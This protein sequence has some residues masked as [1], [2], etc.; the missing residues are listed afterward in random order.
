MLS[1]PLY[2]P[3]F[4]LCLKTAFSA[5][6]HASSFSTTNLC[7][8]EEA[9]ALL[10]F[11]TS[12]SINYTAPNHGL[13]HVIALD[14]SCS[15]LSGTFPSN[16]T[17]FLLK[18]LQSLSLS[19]ID[20]RLSKISP[21]ISQFTR[22]KHLDISSSQ[23]SG[24]VPAEIAH[25][26]KLVSLNLSTN[27]GSLNLETATLRNLVHNLSE[28]SEL[29]LSGV[30]MTSVNPRFFMNPSSS[31][32]TLDLSTCELRGNFPNIIFRF[33]NLKIFGLLGNKNL[34]IDLPSSNW[35]SPLQSLWLEATDC[36]RGL[37][38][39]IGDLK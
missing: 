24:Q 17:L 10:Q 11:K 22:L 19:F 20:F 21:K 14:L 6:L 36:G 18:N 29:V 28:V 15:L 9:A 37:P 13:C 34:T 16:S 26:A 4:F 30:N 2:L 1:M 3:F 12:F 8:H 7:S 27:F 38:E 33:P 23:F 32:T 39:S 31:L 35:S 5:S 25:L